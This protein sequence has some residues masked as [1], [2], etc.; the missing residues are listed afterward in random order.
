MDDIRELEP[1][2]TRAARAA[3]LY[4]RAKCGDAPFTV[5]SLVA[6]AQKDEELR[7]M[8][9]LVAPDR[10]GIGLSQNMLTRW[11]KA[12]QD[13]RVPGTEITLASL[14]VGTWQYLN[15]EEAAAA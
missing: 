15:E 5:I 8:L 13:R 1:P 11:L 4:W 6:L 7:A 2:A 9:L 10:W 14:G 3:A 12:Q